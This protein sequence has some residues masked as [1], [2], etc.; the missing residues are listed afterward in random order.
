MYTCV[1]IYIYI[2]T[3][4]STI[5]IY[6]HTHIH[7]DGDPNDHMFAEP[8]TLMDPLT[9]GIDTHHCNQERRSPY[10]CSNE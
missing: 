4:V 10:I 7:I 5:H 6:T 3:H 1:C 8:R 2:S 9:T